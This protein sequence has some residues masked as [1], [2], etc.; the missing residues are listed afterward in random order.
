MLCV[1][2]TAFFAS[3]VEHESK[4]CNSKG[5]QRPGSSAFDRVYTAK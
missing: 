4:H 1:F 5:F 3:K 2:L